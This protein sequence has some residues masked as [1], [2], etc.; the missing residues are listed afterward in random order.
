MKDFKEL[1]EG[2]S[3]YFQIVIAD[4]PDLMKKTHQLR[5]EVFCKE[6]HFEREEDCPGGQEQDEYDAQSLHCLIIHRSTELPAGCVRLIRAREV[7]HAALLPIE[8]YCEACFYPGPTHPQHLPRETL[9]EISRLAVSSYFRRRHG[10]SNSPIGATQSLQIS[11]E[12]EIRTF[13]LISLALF[14][15]VLSVA[16]ISQQQDSLS[17]M[18]PW[19]ARQLRLMGFSFQQ[20]GEVTEYHGARAPFHYTYGQAISD[21]EQRPMLRQLFEI[22]DP[23]I[24]AEARRTGLLAS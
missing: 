2:F 15:S 10:E 9:C 8:R 4:T 18:E 13:P 16:T 5:Y 19:L 20:I 3:R 1:M 22:I 14:L 11:N 12:L 23:L 7:D 6:F 24:Q 21:K 17:V